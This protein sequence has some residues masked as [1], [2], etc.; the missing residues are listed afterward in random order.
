VEI[1]QDSVGETSTDTGTGASFSL[2]GVALAGHLLFE[3]AVVSDASIFYSI[4]NEDVPSEWEVGLGIYDE[5]SNTVTRNTILSSS[6]SNAVVNFSAG[7]KRV[8]LTLA[9]TKASLPDIQT[10]TSNGTW[11]KPPGA[12]HTTIYAIGQGGGGA[13]GRGPAGNV[14]RGGGGGAGGAVTMVTLAADDLGATESVVVGSAAN[15]GAAQTVDSTNGVSGTAGVATQFG[16]KVYAHGGSGGEFGG[17]NNTGG[18]AG[19]AVGVTSHFQ[20]V[21]VAGGAAA[22]AGGTGGTGTTST[23]GVPTGGGAASGI[24]SADADSSGAGNGGSLS[25]GIVAVTTAGGSAASGGT[26]SI[27]GNGNSYPWL[28]GTTLGTGG[29][30]GRSSKTAAGGAG[31]NGGNYGAGGGGGGASLNGNASGAGGNGG[32]G[33]CVVISW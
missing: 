26:G 13:G 11:T 23:T 20:Q 3:G 33:I 30:G 15:G 8:Y 24:T 29:G 1:Y 7:T 10:F 31:G 16:T 21:S 6:N 2:S 18:A 25:Q 19:A 27:G 28:F 22:A 32:G 4:W 17:F 14:R 5:F 9:A 12:V